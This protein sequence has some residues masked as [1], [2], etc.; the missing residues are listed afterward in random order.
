MP[1]RRVSCS[2]IL[3]LTIIVALT[4]AVLVSRFDRIE[5]H[6]G[7]V[8][9]DVQRVAT[10]GLP[11]PGNEVIVT[12]DRIESRA[13][14]DG[15][16][17]TRN[18]ILVI[19]DGMGLGALSTASTLL[20]GPDGGLQVES[21]PVVGLVRTW[22]SND[23]VTG[24]A[25]SASAMATGIKT[26][27]KKIAM[28]DDGRRHRTLLEAAAI[29]GLSTG[30]ITTSGLVDATPASFLSHAASRYDFRPILEQMLMSDAEVLIGGD[31]TRHHRAKKDHEYLE[32]LQDSD[33]L[34]QS[35]RWIIT[36]GERLREAQTPMIA[37]FPPRSRLAYAHGPALSDS[38][39]FA[40]DVL[41]RNPTGFVLVV[42]CEEPDEGAHS[43]DWGRLA[44]GIEEL[45]LATKRVLEFARN[46]HETLVIVTAD[47]DAAGTALVQG[48]F[49][50]AT[51]MVKWVSND[52]TGSW[53]PLFAFGPGAA[54]FGGVMD[55]TQIGIR[56]ADLLGL[57]GLPAVL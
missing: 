18:V 14:P 37:L 36:D 29:H 2:T 45:D 49:D 40:L 17:K 27:R 21:A 12:P 39:D 5:L 35:G 26:P 33:A 43:N 41:S 19:G 23:A 30:V 51:A 42:E 11:V 47:H 48:R 13:I 57:E 10:V 22:A 44:D 1:S 16:T 31:F 3:L 15:R 28:G 7:G 55:N 52:H 32:L 24:S 46:H 53:V 8:G 20:F 4:G 54:R 34:E 56:I 50:A 25:A 6:F 9:V 38:A